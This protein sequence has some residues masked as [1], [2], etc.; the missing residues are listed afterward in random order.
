MGA[1]TAW[2]DAFKAS[3]NQKKKRNKKRFP[4]TWFSLLVSLPSFRFYSFY[5]D[6]FR[7]GGFVFPLSF[8]MSVLSFCSLSFLGTKYLGTVWY[9]SRCF[10]SFIFC[11]Y[12]CLFAFRLFTRPCCPR[13]FLVKSEACARSVFAFVLNGKSA[14]GDDDSG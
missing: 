11:H 13:F 4:K 7:F 8:I 1:S 3:F 6:S 9:I 14:G 12:C 10:F 2:L 5:Q